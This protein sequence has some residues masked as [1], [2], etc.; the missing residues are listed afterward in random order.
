[1]VI[2]TLR[3]D[4]PVAEI[5]LYNEQHQFA[6]ISFQAHRKLAE[7]LHLQIRQLLHTN[8]LDWKNIEGIVVYKGPG[9]FTGLRIG[10]S[11]AN[12]LSAAL[13]VPVVSQTSEEWINLGIVRILNG[14]NEVMSLPEYG[15]PPHITTP[16]K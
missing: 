2:L 3:T 9:S 16:R 5:G 4:N 6:Y 8:D 15:A 12:A 7:T 11:V 1:M 10:L 13:S 14:V